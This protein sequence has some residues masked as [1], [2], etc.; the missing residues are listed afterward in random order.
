MTIV[1]LFCAA[2]DQHRVVLL[3]DLLQ[4]ALRGNGEVSLRIAGVNQPSNPC[5]V[6]CTARALREPWIV[7]LFATDATV[8]AVRLDD[9]PLPGPCLRAVNMQRWPARSADRKV[10]SLAQWLMH[11]GDAEPA[12]RAARSSGGW[13]GDAERRRP[14][15]R[16]SD[17]G[18]LLIVLAVLAGGAALLWFATP[19]PSE[20]PD[21]LA[22]DPLKLDA[23]DAAAFASG[24]LGSAPVIPGTD[25]P[26][27][28]SDRLTARGDPMA[29]RTPAAEIY[30]GPDSTLE[31]VVDGVGDDAADA[32]DA[33]TPPT[34]PLPGSVL[35][36]V[37]ERR[38]ASLAATADALAHLCHADSVAAAHAWARTL[39]WRQRQRLPAEACVQTLLERPAFADLRTLLALP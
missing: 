30:S 21:A 34:G 26:A 3:A 38:P 29:E 8:V 11:R 4:R 27:A 13:H 39:N 19:P 22:E 36:D 35:R 23:G 18:R 10:V 2:E 6:A 31:F 14:R 17:L 25:T 12:G 5:L 20:D 24:P 33:T 9:T 37:S 16:M 15:R 1:D 32:G 28:A 7:D